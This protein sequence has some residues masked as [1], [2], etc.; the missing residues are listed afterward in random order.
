M[1]QLYACR[2]LLIRVHGESE[3]LRL[4]KDPVDHLRAIASARG[5]DVLPAAIHIAKDAPRDTTLAWIFGAAV[6]AIEPLKTEVPA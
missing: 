4:I 6:E 3:Y 5:E 1:V 2:N